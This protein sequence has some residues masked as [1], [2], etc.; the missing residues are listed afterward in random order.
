[1]PIHYP[2]MRTAKPWGHR[3]QILIEISKKNTYDLGLDSLLGAR[4]RT[5]MRASRRQ[6]RI[7][8]G[9][10]LDGAKIHAVKCQRPSCSLRA[11][12]CRRPT[13]RAVLQ[14]AGAEPLACVANIQVITKKSEGKHSP[15]FLVFFA[16]PKTINIDLETQSKQSLT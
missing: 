10:S 7:R 14:E 6:V 8:R 3:V 4:H 12:L 11:V 16:K 5:V 1:M 13:L 2:C 15:M 9:Y